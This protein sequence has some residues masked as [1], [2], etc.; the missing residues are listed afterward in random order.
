MAEPPCRPRS[1]TLS[2]HGAREG[3]A[4]RAQVFSLWA[5]PCPLPGV[6]DPLGGADVLPFP[7]S[8]GGIIAADLVKPRAKRPRA[9]AGRWRP[10]AGA[11]LAVLAPASPRP[12]LGLLGMESPGDP[13]CT[14]RLPAAVGRRFAEGWLGS[15]CP[16]PPLPCGA[17]AARGLGAGSAAAPSCNGG[18]K[19]VEGAGRPLLGSRSVSG[20]SGG[21]GGAGA[22]PRPLG[23]APASKSCGN[24]A[25]CCSDK[26][27]AL[28]T[29]GGGGTNEISQ[30]RIQVRSCGE[31]SARSRARRVR[32]RSPPGRALQS[33]APNKCKQMLQ[34]CLN[35]HPRWLEI[36]QRDQTLALSAPH[37]DLYRMKCCGESIHFCKPQ[38]G[39]HLDRGN[40]R[41][42]TAWT[43]LWP[44]QAA[45]HGPPQN[46]SMTTNRQK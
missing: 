39:V 23:P 25:S 10:G 28:A 8:P 6:S 38:L 34:R 32:F 16:P 11:L 24:N 27:I 12:R 22:G 18:I 31:V 3:P 29:V 2:V 9:A 7:S 19:S 17:A 14:G 21:G 46:L 30:E 43:L 26:G 33:R 37:F 36:F 42:G 4:P 15:P 20:V 41:G 45:V 5:L 13:A 1:L 44:I 40:R 35:L